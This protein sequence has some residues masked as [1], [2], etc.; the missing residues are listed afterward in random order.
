MCLRKK[1]LK[2]YNG[3]MKI[4]KRY[5]SRLQKE[6]SVILPITILIIIILNLLVPKTQFEISKDNLSHRDLAQQ[7]ITTNQFAQA[8]KEAD[9]VK[10]I[11]LSL[12][13][14]EI[15]NQPAEIEKE[16]VYLQK[17]AEQ[18]SNYRDIY[19]KLAILNWKL[20]RPFDFQKYLEKAL[21]IDPNNEVIK[22]FSLL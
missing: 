20:Y 14:Q 13:I 12:K 16:I 8:K 22:R 15:E 5:F 10:D 18:F 19:L 1:I 3:L 17:I 4:F 21:E 11:E 2:R 6:L 7:L 9:F